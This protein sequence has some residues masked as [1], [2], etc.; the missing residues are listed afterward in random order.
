M[1]VGIAGSAFGADNPFIPANP[2]PTPTTP[3]SPTLMPVQGGTPNV[4]SP[5][6]PGA[7]NPNNPSQGGMPS[8]M[9]TQMNNRM[10]NQIGQPLPNPTGVVPNIPAP[11][12]SSISDAL[13]SKE[14]KKMDNVVEEDPVPADAVFVGKFNHKFM[15]KSGG[16][17]FF[18]A[19]EVSTD[20]PSS[21]QGDLGSPSPVQSGIGIPA[22]MPS[23]PIPGQPNRIQTPMPAP[24]PGMA[25]QIN[26]PQVQGGPNGS[27]RPR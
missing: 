1:L 8:P 15:Y 3:G 21:A 9:Q 18:R 13:S 7:M 14:P 27:H 24:Q 23:N 19:K 6:Q 11:S 25:P 16:Q 26:N 22:P 10:G 5:V 20:S 12:P 17:Y 2:A 4:P